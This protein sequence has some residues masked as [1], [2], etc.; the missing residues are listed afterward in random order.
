MNAIFINPQL[1]VQ[2]NDKFTTG[3]VYMPITLAYV[4]SNFKKA[5][6]KTKLIDLYGRNPTKCSKENNHL[7]FGEKVEDI[8]ENEFENVDCIFINA[9]Q[10]GNHISILNI[11]KF[12]KLSL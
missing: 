6:I 3:I 4:I 8:D 9:N 1:V 11:I 2:K 5:N 12:I 10:V 7:I